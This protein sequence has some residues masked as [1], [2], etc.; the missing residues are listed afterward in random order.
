[1]TDN[2]SIAVSPSEWDEVYADLSNRY[3]VGAPFVRLVGGPALR[4]TRIDVE[5]GPSRAFRA[6]FDDDS[7]LHV[8]EQE[9]GA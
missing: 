3:R 5:Y 6:H 2:T 7:Y 4:I 1:M 9:P 8:Q